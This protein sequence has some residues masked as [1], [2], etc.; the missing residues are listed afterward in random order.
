MI[1]EVKPAEARTVRRWRSISALAFVLSAAGGLL[2]A[3]TSAPPKGDRPETETYLGYDRSIQLSAEQEKIRVAALEALPAPCCKNFSAATCCCKCNMARATWGLA[4][5]LIAQKGYDAS[6]VREAVAA[7]HRAINPRG[8]SGE[9]CFNGGC[10]RAFAKD[11][12]GG[13]KENEL[14]Y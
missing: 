5:H 14:I 4:K 7:W 12:C 9:S 10:S 6:R 2:L 11:G 1:P 13:M 3:A 8:F